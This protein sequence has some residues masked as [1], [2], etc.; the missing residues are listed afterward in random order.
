LETDKRSKPVATTDNLLIILRKDPN[1]RGFAL[2]EFS[3]KY[4][5]TGPV[6]WAEADVLAV[7]GDGGRGWADS[8]DAGLQWYIEKVY[9][10]YS[11]QKLI[12]ALGLVMAERGFNPVRE[13]LESL[14]WDGEK[15]IDRLLVDY[16][17]AEDSKYT[18]AV[19][20]KTLLG[21][22]ARI[23]TPG[24]KFDNVLVL[25]GP[26]GA[27]KS[28]LINVL[29]GQWYS[30]NMGRLDQKD[31]M[32]NIQG[33]WIMEV[34]E[35]A[36]FKK[37]EIETIKHFISKQKDEFRPAYGR[38][39]QA[40]PRQCIFIG[41]SNDEKFIQDQTGGRRFWPV[42]VVRA[43]EFINKILNDLYRQRLQIWA[44]AVAAWKAGE[45]LHLG[46][47]MEENARTVQAG[48]TEIDPWAD[49]ILEY[50][51]KLIPE[52]WAS[53]QLFDRKAFLRGDDTQPAGAYQ[54]SAITVREI[55]LECIGE[56]IGKINVGY[57]KRIRQILKNSGNWQEAD[58][59]KKIL[60]QAV[61]WFMRKTDDL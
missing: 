49:D 8:D 51:D 23:M 36:G 55:W 28:K 39:V 1:L 3:S 11:V 32:E 60:G 53:M 43:N 5:V 26:Q 54:R 57:S 59:K 21:A 40:F 44:E 45:A 9:G 42:P 14:V 15:R 56:T 48:H 35:L 41:S 29:G 10:I 61:R 30:E 27:A 17:G 58:R 52:N 13:Y 46:A 50:L 19:T 25:V 2:N 7:G 34:P 24:V 4:T 20:R 16:L 37:Q 31:A 18:R 22:V 12:A 6:P 47:E 33:V 38:R